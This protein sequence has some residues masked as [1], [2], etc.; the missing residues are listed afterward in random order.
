MTNNKM[1]NNY[2]NNDYYND[3][4][5]TI[6]YDD[7]FDRQLTK[8]NT[9]RDFSRPTEDARA[10]SKAKRTR[11]NILLSC[12]AFALVAAIAV[13]GMAAGGLFNQKP[14][15][16]TPTATVS[17]T[18]DKGANK[19]AQTTKQATPQTEAKQSNTAVKPT[20]NTTQNTTQNKSTTQTAQNSTKQSAT[21]QSAT[22]QAAT[23]QTQKSED[24]IET[25]NGERV[26]KDTKRQAPDK[27]G[28]PAHY[29]ANGKT[30]YGFNWDYDTDNANFVVKCDYN[31][32][33]Q[34]YDFTFYGSTPGTAHVTLYYYT[35]DTNKVPVNLTVTVDSNLNVSVG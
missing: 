4:R 32:N 31:F 14:T 34:Q 26:Y 13:G 35:S 5:T 7:N 8:E 6:Y 16:T 1:N 2:R 19:A 12:A 17:A 21:Q 28:T 30:S 15:T 22:Q 29:Y 18:V 3:N 33:Q 9:S 20:Q 27:T 23:Q 10:Y 11:Q 24:K 25:V